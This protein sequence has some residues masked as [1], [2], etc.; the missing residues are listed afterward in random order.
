MLLPDRTVE[1]ELLAQLAQV[2][3]RPILA[4]VD[5]VGRGAL[6]GPASVGIS[7][8]DDAA[9]DFP[10][11]LR[12]SK[13]L[14]PARRAGLVEPCKAWTLATV[15]G[16]STVD[17]INEWGIMGGLRAAAARAV[18]QI[19]ALG[20][21]FD[22][23]LL[24]G[25]HD[26]WTSAA[27]VPAGPELPDLPVHMEVKG[28]A[29]CAVVAA[30]SVVAKVERDAVMKDLDLRFPGYDWARNKGYSSP[31]HIAALGELGPSAAHRTSWHLPG[32][33]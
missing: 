4:G 25:S 31:S 32:V 2:S 26:W 27:L 8:I 10:P 9:G 33:N 23:V 24:D 15:V 13:L 6:A 14:S 7:L 3:S 12:D 1:L 29:R 28:D 18:A 17:E 19:E 30:A 5:E 20:L 16:H 21:S 11:G 22:G